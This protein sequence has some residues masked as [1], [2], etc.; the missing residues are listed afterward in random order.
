MR[1]GSREPREAGVPR[2]PGISGRAPLTRDQGPR[3][4]PPPGSRERRP[5]GPAR[6]TPPRPAARTATGLDFPDEAGWSL[7]EERPA[8]PSPATAG[9][10]GAHPEDL[11]DDAA[12]ILS[13]SSVFDL[14]GEP[15]DPDDA[16]LPAES[17]LTDEPATAPLRSVVGV[18]I[19]DGI[20]G[21]GGKLVEFDAAEEPLR[22]GDRVVVETERGLTIGTVVIPTTRRLT[23]GPLRRFVRR[24]DPQDTR[25]QK[26]NEARER[27]AYEFCRQR[28]TERR[29]PMKLIRAEYQHA[30]NR[31]TFYFASESRIDFRELVKDLARRLHVRVE[32]RQVGVR[33]EARMTG[34]IGSCGRELCCASWLQRFEPVSI[35]MAKDQNLVLNPSKVSGQC[36]RLK[37]CLAYEQ[38][39]YQEARK[40]L[41]KV[42]KRV[43]TPAGEGIVVELDVP[44]RLVRVRC[45]AGTYE[46]FPAQQV[47]LAAPP[48]PDDSSSPPRD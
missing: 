20:Q 5:G 32:M 1:S 17:E 31:A 2:E 36:G 27:E 9:G 30:G 10:L 40:Q 41:P 15:A 4:G 43:N 25:A 46:V 26:R 3:R 7:E 18:R 16:T 39:V 47:S 28:V 8:A 14:A 33:D 21:E 11:P 24:V 38:Q 45:A 37:C 34:G 48:A 12:P 22:Q 42:G 19:S 29:L 35:R 44:R 23:K 13:G 6:E